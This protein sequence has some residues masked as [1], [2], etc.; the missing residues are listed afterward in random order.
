MMKSLDI[1]LTGPRGVMKIAYDLSRY[2]MFRKVRPSEE[3]SRCDTHSNESVMWS[4]LPPP[5]PHISAL[6][7]NTKDVAVAPKD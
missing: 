4:P 7:Y 2:L 5:P 6:G 1:R 3:A